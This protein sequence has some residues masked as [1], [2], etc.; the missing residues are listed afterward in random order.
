MTNKVVHGVFSDGPLKG[1]KNGYRSFK[2]E[3][4]PGTNIGSYHVLDGQ[5]VT[6]RYP[7]Q[8]QTCARCLQTSQ[9]CRGKGLAKNCEAEGGIKLDFRVYIANLLRKI[10]YSPPSETPECL[11]EAA[12]DDIT[13]KEG[14]AFTPVKIHSA[15]KKFSGVSV[16]QFPRGTDQGEIVEFFVGCGLPDGKRDSIV[17]D[18]RGTVTI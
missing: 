15:V 11:D 10:G 5:R 9:N 14:G 2:M 13:Q 1:F 17:F 7:G 12:E 16:K 6:M 18:N 3:V 4:K 8:Q